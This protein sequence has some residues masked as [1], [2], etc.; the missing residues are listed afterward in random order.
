MPSLG[1]S[2]MERTVE[3][4]VCAP[5]VLEPELRA[6]LLRGEAAEVERVVG[7]RFGAAGAP[8]LELWRK[9]LYEQTSIT[10]ADIDRA[11]SGLGEIGAPE[12]AL[13]ELVVLTAHSVGL[14]QVNQGLVALG[15]AP[16][17]IPGCAAAA[18][19][20][21]RPPRWGGPPAGRSMRL[22]AAHR[23]ALGTWLAFKV[24]MKVVALLAGGLPVPDVLL[25][26]GHRIDFWGLHCMDAF[27]YWMCH[28][29]SFWQRVQ[30][31]YMAGFL[32][33]LNHC[34]F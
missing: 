6:A 18:A 32:S 5:G 11:L 3:D 27:Q 21:F 34:E 19:R 1:R 14:Q 26:M 28:A 7:N 13:F 33:R 12:E 25:S 17:S 23:T 2:I 24:Q 4:L 15:E 31:E 8:L 16:Y 29:D 20:P 9:I 30:R 22:A 10:Q